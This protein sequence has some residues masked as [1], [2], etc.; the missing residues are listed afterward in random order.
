MTYYSSVPAAV[1]ALVAAF[2]TS[3]ALAG[4][5]VHDGPELADAAGLEGIAVGWT[6]DPNV[7][8][9]TGTATPEGLAVSPGRERYAV[10]CLVE[11][12][13]GGG[14]IAAARTRAYQLHAA[15]GAAVAVDPRLGGVVLYASLG[16]GSLRQQQ[17]QAGALAW[18]TFPVNVD[19]Y[20]TR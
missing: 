12:I 7:D 14:S 9:V 19:A 15:C 17:T 11:V 20:T 3:V 10:A 16:I 13:D 6:G 4:V 8:V 18:V 5:P 2:K 1:A